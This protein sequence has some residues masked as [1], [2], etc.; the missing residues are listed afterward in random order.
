MEEGEAVKREFGSRG[1]PVT[2]KANIGGHIEYYYLDTQERFGCLIES[3][4]GHA[5]DFVKPAYV[6]P[7]AEAA[8]GTSTP[9][10]EITQ[11]TVVVRDLDA[12]LRAYHEAFGWGPWKIFEARGDGLLHD[13]ELDGKPVAPFSARWAQAQVGDLNFELIEP[14]GGDSPWQRI[15]DAKGEGIGSVTIMPKAGGRAQA[16]IE[17][18]AEA[19]CR[20]AAKTDVGPDMTWYYLDSE[21]TF[22]CVIG[23]GDGHAIDSVAPA[24]TYPDASATA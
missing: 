15:L 9:S 7:D 13:C 18:L 21:P 24:R 16:V 12:R 19:G 23:T 3:G 14:C 8:A 20:V 11:L 1:M 4:S 10:C 5:A 2:M 17:Q 6:Y 22:K